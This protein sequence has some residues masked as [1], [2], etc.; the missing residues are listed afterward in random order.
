VVPRTLAENAGK[1][2]TDI[3][4][5]LYK[6]HEEGG[7]T[8]GVD[9]DVRPDCTA[10]RRSRE[11][12]LRSRRC[13]RLSHHPSSPRRCDSQEGGVCD[14][15]AREVFDS[16]MT[17]VSAIRL[18]SDAAITV[19]RVDQIIMSKAAGGPKPREARPGDM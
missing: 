11:R 10:P 19:L 6:A 3:M 2:A 7:V 16:Y 4:S 5:A 9:I 12:R 18:A 13:P 14:A 15:E 8:C 17:K 1:D